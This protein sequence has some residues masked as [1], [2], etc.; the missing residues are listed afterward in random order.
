MGKL[1]AII[2]AALAAG[3]NTYNLRPIAITADRGVAGACRFLGQ[4]TVAAHYFKVGDSVVAAMK[5]RALALSGNL[6]I[7][8][9][10]KF[11]Q[12]GPTATMTGDIYAC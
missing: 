1:L 11:S 4:E 5:N 10:P 3:C 12:P 7:S 2:A 6:V 9:G 8:D